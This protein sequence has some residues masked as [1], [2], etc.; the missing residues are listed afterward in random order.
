[1]RLTALVLAFFACMGERP[2]WPADSYSADIGSWRK[3]YGR[4][5][6]A[7]DGPFSLVA[8]WT[9]K[10]G[11]SSVGRDSS[12]ELVVPVE[13]A[14]ARIG[15]IEWLEGASATLRLEPGIRAT[16]QGKPVSEIRIS[17][18]V[19]VTVGEIQLVLRFRETELRVTLK[20]LN[21]RTR[22][23][24]KPSVWFAVDQRYRI[25]ADWVPFPEPKTIRIP[26]ND[27]GSRGWKSPGYASFALDGKN[28]TMQAIL[29]PDG[30]ELSFLFRDGTAGKE[31]YGAG[32]FLETDLPKNGKV[33]VDFN[34]AYNPS[35][36]FNPLYVCPIPPKENHLAMR[37][38]AGERNYP[39]PGKH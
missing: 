24:A 1:M 19:T 27:G 8:R 38:P 25:T 22:K 12:N 32:R 20:D 2:A 3:Q 37:I 7:P 35:C 9:P 18:P 11:V 5:L 28:L 15:R 14:P 34:K 17:E 23:E 36:A 10:R 6:L 4:D 29:T 39:H 16:V 30:K 21:A 33:I 31:T 26:D 13:A